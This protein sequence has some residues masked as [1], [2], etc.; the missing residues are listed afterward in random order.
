M[1]AAQVPQAPPPATNGSSG[2]DDRSNLMAQIQAG[3]K[4][5]HVAAPVEKSGFT[6]GKTAPTN[7]RDQ[8]MDQIKQG[9]QLKHVSSIVVTLTEFKNGIK[10]YIKVVEIRVH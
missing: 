7:S 1:I 5:K 2:G 9:T 3:A 4:L 8:M 10:E 6:T